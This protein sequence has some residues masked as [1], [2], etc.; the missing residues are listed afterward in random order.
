VRVIALC[1]SS[2]RL[3]VTETILETLAGSCPRLAVCKLSDDQHL[4]EVAPA[5]ARARESKTPA[6]PVVFPRL[7][8]LTLRYACAATYVARLRMPSLRRL[9]LHDA[10][11]AQERADVRRDWDLSTLFEHS[12]ALELLWMSSVF[13]GTMTC[14]PVTADDR[15]LTRLRAVT[16]YA[17]TRQQQQQQQQQQ[18]LR[19]LLSGVLGWCTALE[20][21]HLQR[22]HMRFADLEALA[23]AAAFPALRSLRKLSCDLNADHGALADLARV[24]A[25]L[26][27]TLEHCPALTDVCVPSGVC[28]HISCE[29]LHPALLYPVLRLRP[30]LRLKLCG[31]VIEPPE[32]VQKRI[33]SSAESPS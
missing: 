4:P 11:V 31:Q 2:K 1:G 18:G 10:P 13:L 26:V 27:R 23:V 22:D 28:A 30:Q 20:S 29:R 5:E 9:T 16:L 12:P 24:V 32:R 7:T 3:Q 6:P 15:P 25:R 14:R 8:E 19:G 33:P 17:G 21:L